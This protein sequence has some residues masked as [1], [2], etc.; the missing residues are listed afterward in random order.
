MRSAAV[1]STRASSAPSG[2]SASAHE[3]SGS[4]LGTNMVPGSLAGSGSGSAESCGRGGH[5]GCACGAVRDALSGP[6][7]TASPLSGAAP[8][9]PTGR[10]RGMGRVCRPCAKA[11]LRP[12]WARPGAQHSV[13]G[14]GPSAASICAHAAR[15]QRQHSRQRHHDQAQASMQL[16][17]QGLH[18]CR[19][20]SC[21]CKCWGWSADVGACPG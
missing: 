11:P 1:R 20:C 21:T 8:A 14:S 10:G 5:S 6:G 13:G 15:R 2:G 7:F 12:P 9:M 19:E 16:M 3:G 4:R 17:R 18:V